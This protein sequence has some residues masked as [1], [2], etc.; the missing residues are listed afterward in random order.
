MSQHLQNLAW[1]IG[2]RRGTPQ[3]FG[4]AIG[5][6]VMEYLRTIPPIQLIYS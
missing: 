1:C 4:F 2:Y 6:G 3:V 5:N